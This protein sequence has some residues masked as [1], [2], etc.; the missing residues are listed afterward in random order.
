MARLL[1]PLPLSEIGVTVDVGRI[2]AV[3]CKNDKD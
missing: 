3:V 1:L 2:Q